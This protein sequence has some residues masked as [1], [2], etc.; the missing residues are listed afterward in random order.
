MVSIKFYSHKKC[1]ENFPRYLVDSLAIVTGEPEEVDKIT[2]YL[3]DDFPNF[4]GFGGSTKFMIKDFEHFTKLLY[5]IYEFY[6]EEE[7]IVNI[8]FS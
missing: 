8:S 1:K 3:A 5:K 7:P 4:F 6:G 2:D